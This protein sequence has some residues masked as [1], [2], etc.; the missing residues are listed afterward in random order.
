MATKLLSDL[1]RDS[2]C[3]STGV[4]THALEVNG[5]YVYPSDIKLLPGIVE[6]D[7]FSRHGLWLVDEGITPDAHGDCEVSRFLADGTTIGKR[8]V[9]MRIYKIT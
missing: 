9:P 5:M 7:D 6:V 4:Q 1:L 8:K 2:G 3:I